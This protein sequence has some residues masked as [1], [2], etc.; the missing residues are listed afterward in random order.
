M[1]IHIYTILFLLL[2]LLPVS[3]TKS[4]LH[5]SNASRC[6]VIQQRNSRSNP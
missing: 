4:L 3:A 2:P 1:Y 5:S 6:P